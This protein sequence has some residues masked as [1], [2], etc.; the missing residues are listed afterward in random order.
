[1]FAISRAG[2]RVARAVVLA[3]VLSMTPLAGAAAQAPMAA[4]AL[5]TIIKFFRA[6]GYRFVVL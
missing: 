2:Q 3:F 5:P 6:R 4:P 1:M